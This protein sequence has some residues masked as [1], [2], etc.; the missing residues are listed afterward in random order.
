MFAPSQLSGLTNGFEVSPADDLDQYPL[1]SPPVELPGEDL[2][3]RAEV[4]LATTTTSRPI[5]CRLRCAS[6]LSS[7]VRL[8]RKMGTRSVRAAPANIHNHHGDRS[9]HR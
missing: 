4:E 7:P 1:A 3:P 5:T 9:R 8:W 6:P 2:L